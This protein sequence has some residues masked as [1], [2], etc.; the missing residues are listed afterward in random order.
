MVAAH[1]PPQVDWPNV[2]ENDDGIRPAGPPDAC[3][4][5]GQPV[6]SPHNRTCVVVTRRV[7]VRYSFDIEIDV[8]YFWTADNIDFHRNKSS[9]CA[10]NALADI[11]AHQA[12]LE[13]AGNCLCGSFLCEVLDMGDGMPCQSTARQEPK[14]PETP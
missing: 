2:V 11:E 7:R 12:A 9:W 8:P 5:C 13:Q 10:D 3:F 1:E 14:T 4:Y 6:G